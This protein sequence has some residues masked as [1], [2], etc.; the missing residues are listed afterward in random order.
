MS[1]SDRRRVAT[2]L[3]VVV[4][5]LAAGC[6]GGGSL[7]DG[8]DGGTAAELDRQPD[9]EETGVPGSA[10]RPEETARS[11]EE[12][13]DTELQA[14]QRAIIRTGQVVLTVD[15][16]DAAERNLTRTAES[17]GGFVSDSSVEVN[18]VDNATYKTGT[19]VLRVPSENFSAMMD[20][21]ETVGEVDSTTVDSE[22]VTDQLVDITARLDNLKAERQ[23]LRQLYRNATDT[24]DV[25]A[26][27]R[28]LS[29]VQG[30]IERLEAR[31]EE[32]ERRVALS[33]IRVNLREPRPD[34]AP[35]DVDRWYDTPVVSAFLESVDGV[36]TTLRAFVVAG[37]YALPYLLVFGPVLAAA[38]YVVRRRR[39]RGSGPDDRALSEEI[40][41]EG[42]DSGAETSGE[43]DDSETGE[44][45]E[46][47][48]DDE[49]ETGEK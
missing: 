49:T 7:A 27:E 28:R 3:G 15:E 14:R 19:L 31:K 35:L 38:G 8:G 10:D 22:D 39:N 40:E 48:I 47:E 4:L 23:R 42:D 45:T 33:T 2:V 36:V 6:S 20:H 1:V 13:G 11:R 18:R 5:A 43:D 32:L 46:G 25:L 24:E 26:V 9:A 34:P 29:E 21:A 30:E 44:E 16:F 41:E 12:S 17:Y 37:A